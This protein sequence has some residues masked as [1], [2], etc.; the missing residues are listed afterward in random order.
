MVR[1]LD[2][3]IFLTRGKPEANTIAPENVI[4]LENRVLDIARERVEED[5]ARM[6]EVLHQMRFG[7]IIYPPPEREGGVCT[8]G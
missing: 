5:L 2:V 4:S 7:S 1:T 3:M 8:S 6:K